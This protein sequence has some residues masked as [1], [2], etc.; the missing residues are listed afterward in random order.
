MIAAIENAMVARVLAASEADVLG[1]RL[2]AV[3]A[4]AGEFDNG[5]RTVIKSFPAVWFTFRSLGRGVPGAGD[6]WTIPAIFTAFVATTNR[7]NQQ[8]RRHG[9]AGEV[10]SLQLVRDVRNL[11]LGQRLGL[12]IEPLAPGAVT[13]L[14]NGVVDGIAGSIYACDFHTSWLDLAAGDVADADLDD[15]ATFHADW[16]VPPIGNVAGPLPADNPDASDTVNLETD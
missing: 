5:L 6:S 4:Y 8:A 14:V 2:R 10:G 1:Y 7:R 13:G 16:D 3:A 9:A 12:E 11:L 15:F